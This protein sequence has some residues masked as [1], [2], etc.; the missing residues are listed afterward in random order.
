LALAIIMVYEI[1]VYLSDVRFPASCW[2]HF[3]ASIDQ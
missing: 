1:V 3:Q 2:V